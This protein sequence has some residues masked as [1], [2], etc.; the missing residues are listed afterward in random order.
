MLQGFT[1]ALLDAV[2]DALLAVDAKTNQ[3]VAANGCCEALFDEERAAAARHPRHRE[4]D[5]PLHR[6]S[7]LLLR[8]GRAGL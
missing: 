6:C 1:Q 7:C 3:V 4:F 5:L 2:P 8:H